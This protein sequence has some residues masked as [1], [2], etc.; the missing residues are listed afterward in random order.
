MKIFYIRQLAGGCTTESDITGFA[1]CVSTWT[2]ILNNDRL[3]SRIGADVDNYSLRWGGRLID[4]VPGNEKC[5]QEIRLNARPPGR[6]W[7]VS[8]MLIMLGLSST[9]DLTH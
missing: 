2:L 9:I 7:D 3:N 4:E 1:D 5:S 6:H 8:K